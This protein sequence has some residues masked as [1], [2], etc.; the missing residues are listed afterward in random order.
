M[1]K[2][3][4]VVSL[5][6]VLVSCEKDKTGIEEAQQNMLEPA[7]R[8]SDITSKEIIKNSKLF[9]LLNERGSMLSSKNS[10]QKLSFIY[11]SINDITIDIR[12]AKKITSSN[13]KYHSYTFS[14]ITDDDSTENLL[15]S[16]QSDGTY[17]IFKVDYNLLEIEKK[18]IENGQYIDL[19]GKGSITRL[20]NALSL[21]DLTKS[22]VN[23]TCVFATISYC[24]YGNHAGGY[25]NGSPCPGYDSTTESYC[26]TGSTGGG[27]GSTSD[28]DEPSGG[29][30]GGSTGG[31][32]TSDPDDDTCIADA[33]GNC[34]GDTTTPILE[35]PTINDK[36]IFHLQLDSASTLENWV[37]AQDY[38][39]ISPIYNFLG[40]N[41][42][43][44]ESKSFGLRAISALYNNGDVDLEKRLIFDP[45]LHDFLKSKMSD[46]ELAIFDNITTIEKA[47]YLRAATEAYI[48]AEA[49][50]PNPVR[51]RKGDAVKHSLWNALSTNYIGASLTKQ[52]TDAHE[53]ITY[54]SNYPNHYKETDMD[55]FNNAQ[56]R[57]LATHYGNFIFKLV[58]NALA[59]GELRYLN[60]LEFNGIFWKATN[61]SQL[62][63]TNQ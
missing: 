58:E 17:H 5:F 42:F 16:L 13:G 37:Q 1:K 24:K 33:D 51:N 9:D 34:L 14:I 28:P 43:S 26:S 49:F 10:E 40:E 23:T 57:E 62:T 41:D 35:K 29:G 6:I 3:Y 48:Y 22:S 25:D 63:P 61:S 60:N 36:L 46:S 20:N 19:N 59:N 52:L 39:V 55:L 2:I 38:E 45:S 32:S 8:I 11:D 18:K 44:P 12:Q 31:G 53:E 4:L 7:M 30:G 50:Y 21:N 27:G 54:D 47:G 15:Y 56:G